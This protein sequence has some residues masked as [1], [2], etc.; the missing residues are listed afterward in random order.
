MRPGPRPLPMKPRKV[1]GGV[2][3]PAGDIAPPSSHT[4]WASQRWIRLIEQAAVGQPLVEGLEYARLGQTKRMEIAPGSVAA[5]VQGRSERPYTVTISLATFKPDEWDKVVAA[6][7]EGAIYAAKLLAGELPP[8]IEDIFGPQALKLFP[9][10][11]SELKVECNCA[12][13]MAVYNQGLSVRR[14][15]QSE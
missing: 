12:Q 3:V 5:A 8:N 11:A 14:P 10:D 9:T 6:M 15:W 1:R 7:S 13:V 4:A 2:K